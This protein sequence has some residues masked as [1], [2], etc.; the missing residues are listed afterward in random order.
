M[1]GLV[2][3]GENNNVIGELGMTNGLIDGV[4]AVTRTVFIE[5][6]ESI[7]GFKGKTDNDGWLA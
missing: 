7:I 3:C 4:P 1:R 5:K 6:N 2:F